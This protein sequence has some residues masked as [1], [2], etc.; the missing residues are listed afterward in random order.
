MVSGL[1]AQVRA[2]NELVM[3]LK[4]LLFITLACML[5]SV[6]PL[7]AADVAESD[8]FLSGQQPQTEGT[9]GRALTQEELFS[10]S[11]DEAGCLRRVAAAAGVEW[12]ETENILLRSLEEANEQRWDSALALVEQA[13]F[14]SEQAL[15][16]AEHE[17]EAWKHRVIK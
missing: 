7:R 11:F 8:C 2:S 14:Q 4:T 17:A 1:T 13:R 15:R 9:E 12:L 5:M 3:V 6:K 16:Q 10:Q